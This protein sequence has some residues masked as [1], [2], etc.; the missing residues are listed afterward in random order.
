MK[1]FNSLI[2][3]FLI[4]LSVTACDFF[5]NV[6]ETEEENREIR[7]VPNPVVEIEDEIE[8][9]D[10]GISLDL[11]SP[12]AFKDSVWKYF[13]VILEDDEGFLYGDEGLE[14]MQDIAH[15]LTLFSPG[16]MKVMSD[17]YHNE[18]R[19]TYIIRIEGENDDRYGIAAWRRNIIVTVHYDSDPELNGIT[20]PVLAHE[21]GHTVHFMIEE[22]IGEEQSEADMTALNSEFEYVGDNYDRIWREKL[23]GTAFAY[24]YSM[25]CYYEDI[26]TIFE[27]LVEDPRDMTARL[28]DPYSEILLRKTQYIREMTYKYISDECYLIFMP[29]Y[30]AEEVLGLR[31]A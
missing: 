10:D 29:L 19:S 8:K 27:L 28:S 30:E 12:K 17:Y 1:K 22:F 31:A 18:H 6:I 9:Q 2:I 3:C 5:Y 16:F 21:I 24:D 7:N 25:Y 23:H 15:V 4:I 26:A 11:S 13:Y 14:Y 20:A